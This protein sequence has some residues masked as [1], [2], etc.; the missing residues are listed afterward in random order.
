MPYAPSS[1]PIIVDIFPLHCIPLWMHLR[2]QFSSCIMC[3]RGAYLP[4]GLDWPAF[5]TN[6]I[7]F[8]VDVLT[9][10]NYLADETICSHPTSLHIGWSCCVVPLDMNPLNTLV[11][12]MTIWLQ[13]NH[14]A[15]PMMPG[16]KTGNANCKINLPI[17]GWTALRLQCPCWSVWL[18]VQTNK[19]NVR[20]RVTR[21]H[22]VNVCIM[23]DWPQSAS[24]DLLYLPDCSI[25]GLF[26]I[27]AQFT[28]FIF[29]LTIFA[30]YSFCW[31]RSNQPLWFVNTNNVGR[32]LEKK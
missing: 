32:N 21:N 24:H 14:Q 12:V 25:R 18:T 6:H 23:K 27:V 8:K 17:V 3:L 28:A 10:P 11:T 15:N 20:E 16:M 31:H 22:I 13:K 19:N 26:I 9:W 7:L 30:Q 2:W 4:I 5:R 29:A 1:L